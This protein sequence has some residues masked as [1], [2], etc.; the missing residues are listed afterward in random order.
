MTGL[1]LLSVG[2]IV[3]AAL[4]SPATARERHSASRSIADNAYASAPGAASVDKRGCD[5]AP[6][7]GA[8]ATQPWRK[9]P[10]EPSQGY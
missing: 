7:V 9:P 8:Y 3:A 2:M 6:R 4:A 5:R 10:C 1:K